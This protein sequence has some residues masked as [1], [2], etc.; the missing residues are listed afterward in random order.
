VTDKKKFLLSV[1]DKLSETYIKQYT[2]REVSNKLNKYRK[3]L[4]SY[5]KGDVLE[6]A[7]GTGFGFKNYNVTDID[8][9]VGV[10]WSSG[11]LEQAFET[12]DE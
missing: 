2:R 3:V 8:S 1:Q 5:A 11:M 4:L 10:D 9:Y 6:C 7:V 12:V